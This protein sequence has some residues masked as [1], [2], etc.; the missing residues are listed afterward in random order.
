VTASH[1]TR[2][3]VED[4]VDEMNEHSRIYGISLVRSSRQ[5]LDLLLYVIHVQSRPAGMLKTDKHNA[6]ML[7]NTLYKQLELGSSCSSSD[8]SCHRL[9]RQIS[10]KG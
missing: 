4:L 7:A 1:T 2:T 9:R 6:L 3:P 8:A 10:S 5:E